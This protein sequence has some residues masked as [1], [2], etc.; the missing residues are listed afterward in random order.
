MQLRQRSPVQVQARSA[1]VNNT[2]SSVASETIAEILK[3]SVFS[4]SDSVDSTNAEINDLLTKA[5]NNIKEYEQLLEKF[6]KDSSNTSK[7]IENAKMH[8]HL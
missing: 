7:L 2:F 8:L 1:Q 6:S 5:N 3:D 4:I